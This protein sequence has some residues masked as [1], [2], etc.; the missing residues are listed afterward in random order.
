MR[1]QV[2]DITTSIFVLWLVAK[3]PLTLGF[4]YWYYKGDAKWI[5]YFDIFL[6]IYFWVD[7]LFM[8]NSG[9]VHD[10]HVVMTR[11][12]SAK[13]YFEFW[14]WVDIIA[15]LPYEHMMTRTCVAW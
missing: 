7:M 4:S 12:E 3:V 13:H 11:K 6:D 9:F 1:R 5:Y 15:Q 14:F 10:G 2:W 8:F